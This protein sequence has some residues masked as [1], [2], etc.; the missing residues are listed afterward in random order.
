MSE[1]GGEGG[2]VLLGGGG[3]GGFGG[4]LG[5]DAIA[6][7]F[8]VERADNLKGAEAVAQEV[9]QSALDSVVGAFAF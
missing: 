1:L 8:R 5:E 6:Q 4:S 2:E 7:F 9:S 3:G